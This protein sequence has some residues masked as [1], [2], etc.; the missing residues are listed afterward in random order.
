VLTAVVSGG[1]LASSGL[2]LFVR[3]RR[4]AP[5]SRRAEQGEIV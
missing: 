2:V 3:S 4:L 1:L 5:S